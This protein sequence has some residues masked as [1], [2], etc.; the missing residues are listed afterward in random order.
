[1]SA[2][3]EAAAERPASETI[4]AWSVAAGSART[5]GPC[6]ALAFTT[7]N[8]DTIN[9]VK[10]GIAVY[11]VILGVAALHRIY[12]TAEIALIAEYVIKLKRNCQGIAFQETLAQLQIPYKLV[13]V[14]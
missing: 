6:R 1:M 12:Y 9:G 10:H 8:I 4:A 2:T 7:K 5:I 3:A 13:G 14:H 11:A